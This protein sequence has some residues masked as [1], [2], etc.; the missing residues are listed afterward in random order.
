MQATA[1]NLLK[2]ITNPIVTVIL[3]LLIG[4]FLVLPTGTSPVQ[5]YAALFRGAFGSTNALL[6]TLMCSTPLLFWITY[7][8]MRTF[9]KGDTIPVTW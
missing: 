9:E 2:T 5:A 8:K 4:S 6:G 7:R 3:A 1:K